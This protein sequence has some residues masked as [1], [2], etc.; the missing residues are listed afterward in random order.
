M[1]KQSKLT[2]AA[3]GKPCTVNL[4]P[5][6][7]EDPETTVFAHMPSEDSGMGY[8]SPDHWGCFSCSI[9]H[10]ILDGRMYTTLTKEEISECQVRGLFRT[11]KI[12]IEMGLIK[13][14]L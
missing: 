14:E 6:C 12:F 7:N 11:W 5:Y 1:G 4:Y 2:K 13:I 3:R 9:C 10:D 8:K